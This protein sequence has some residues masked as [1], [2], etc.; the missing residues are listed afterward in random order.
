MENGVARS[1]N[2]KRMRRVGFAT[3]TWRTTKFVFSGWLVHRRCAVESAEGAADRGDDRF[4]MAIR[5]GTGP[6]RGRAFLTEIMPGIHMRYDRATDRGAHQQRQLKIFW[7]SVNSG[8]EEV[9]NRHEGGQHMHGGRRDDA[10]A[11]CT[12]CGR[13]LDAVTGEAGDSHVL[14][15][16]PCAHGGFVD[17][18]CMLDREDRIARGHTDPG[19]CV[20]CQSAWP[21][22]SPA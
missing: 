5:G 16:I 7:R 10:E 18:R 19:P 2:H 20:A 21:E 13:N 14:V 3:G 9:T 12:Y 8:V 17:A 15:P 6:P 11:T 22:G 1:H 4:G